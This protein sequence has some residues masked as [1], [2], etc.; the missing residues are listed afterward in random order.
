MRFSTGAW[1]VRG[2]R[3]VCPGK[4]PSKHKKRR[5]EKK[6]SGEMKR[7]LSMNH[8]SHYCALEKRTRQGDRCL[9][10]NESKILILRHLRNLR[11]SILYTKTDTK[12]R[13]RCRR[14]NEIEGKCI[15]YHEEF[16]VGRDGSLFF[17]TALQ[18]G[19]KIK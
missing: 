14:D 6:H 17:T 16:F 1:A 7:K 18:K 2:T 5:K 11:H 4:I 10:T 15:T 13:R 3:N 8:V 12:Y 19:G 9:E